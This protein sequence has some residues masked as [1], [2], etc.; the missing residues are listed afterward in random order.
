MHGLYKLKEDLVAELEE[1]GEKGVSG[2]TIN[3]I[4]T[5]AHAAKNVCKIIEACEESEYSERGYS[6][7]R[8][9]RDGGSYDGSYD[10]GGSYEGESYARGRGRGAR[11]DAMGRY[12]RSGEDMTHKLRELAAEAPNNAFRQK[13]EQMLGE[14]E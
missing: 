9:Y 2:S 7:R 12:S 3:T 14:M 1:Y 13:I 11:R 10:R 5:L 8:Y 6:S 4:D